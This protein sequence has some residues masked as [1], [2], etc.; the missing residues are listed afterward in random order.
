MTDILGLLISLPMCTSNIINGSNEPTFYISAGLVFLCLLDLWLMFWQP[1]THAK[2]WRDSTYSFRCGLPQILLHIT[3]Q[4][5]RHLAIQLS[6][7]CSCALTT[8]TYVSRRWL[9]L[10]SGSLFAFDELEYGASAKREWPLIHAILVSK[11]PFMLSAIFLF[12]LD[13][14]LLPVTWFA[15]LVT[16]HFSAYLALKAV[17]PALPASTTLQLLV[18]WLNDEVLPHAFIGHK[19]DLAPEQYI[20]LYWLLAQAFSFWVAVWLSSYWEHKQR[21]RFQSQSLPAPAPT[22][23]V[24]KGHVLRCIGV[25]SYII[26]LLVSAANHR[27]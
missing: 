24:F 3:M 17:Q 23:Y 19:P 10:A 26:F 8:T 6:L 4:C 25:E 12:R 5:L 9:L 18:R 1:E 7:R 21:L 14:R 16:Y 11:W 2:K 20:L 27:G 13:T 22:V 15:F